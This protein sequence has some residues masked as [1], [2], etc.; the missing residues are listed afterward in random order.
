MRPFNLFPQSIGSVSNPV[1]KENDSNPQYS[2]PVPTD[3]ISVEDPVKSSVD[4]FKSSSVASF[5]SVP[6]ICP[7]K[8]PDNSIDN[9]VDCNFELVDTNSSILPEC[10]NSVPNCENN[11]GKDPKQALE[12]E[13]GLEPPIGS[14]TPIDYV[15]PP[16]EEDRSWIHAEGI[17]RIY[18]DCLLYTVPK[19]IPQP[20]IVGDVGTPKGVNLATPMN[21]AAGV[22]SGVVPNYPVSPNEMNVNYPMP[23]YPFTPTTISPPIPL[24]NP[25]PTLLVEDPATAKDLLKSNQIPSV[26]HMSSRSQ[27]NLQILVGSPTNYERTTTNGDMSVRSIGPP[28]GFEPEPQYPGTPFT[29]YPID[30]PLTGPPGH[31]YF[32]HST[33]TPMPISLGNPLDSRDREEIA[34]LN[35]LHSKHVITPVTP[36]NLFDIYVEHVGPNNLESNEEVLERRR[37]QYAAIL[38]LSQESTNL[39]ANVQPPAKEPVSPWG[40]HVPTHFTPS[41][42]M[43]KS[44]SQSNIFNEND[45]P[46][47]QFNSMES[48]R[49]RPLKIDTVTGGNPAYNPMSCPLPNRR[50][51]MSSL[52]FSSPTHERRT[53]KMPSAS[54]S[55]FGTFKGIA[56]VLTKVQ[57]QNII[58][59]SLACHPNAIASSVYCESAPLPRLLMS[60]DDLSMIENAHINVSLQKTSLGHLG[61]Q[62]LCTSTPRNYPAIRSQK[63]FEEQLVQQVVKMQGISGIPLSLLL[64]S[65]RLNNSSKLETVNE[66]VEHDSEDG[67]VEDQ[68][69]AQS[70]SQTV[71][72]ETLFDQSNQQSENTAPNSSLPDPSTVVD[73]SQAPLAHERTNP[74]L[75]SDLKYMSPNESITNLKGSMMLALLKA[76]ALKNHLMI[77]ADTPTR[78]LFI[79][80]AYIEELAFLVDTV[81]LLTKH[82]ENLELVQFL[83]IQVS[84]A[85]DM[86]SNLTEVRWKVRAALQ[87]AYWTQ[88]WPGTI[89]PHQIE[90]P[91][92]LLVK[93]HKG[94]KMLNRFL[95]LLDHLYSVSVS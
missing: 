78:L 4:P 67:A 13:G 36:V 94:R 75:G 52:Q 56:P 58:G 38:K 33:T 11:L 49:R 35:I 59:A 27:I 77:G 19:T 16:N 79:Y 74:I 43:H 20:G 48:S 61:R 90:N 24:A 64:K 65:H 45:Y 81:R 1:Y 6:A 83:S 7:P 63:K 72:P 32:A 66:G 26:A 87:Y 40:I 47:G 12:S 89:C 60:G 31:P 71:S 23:A 34:L 54:V 10:V 3:V 53:F 28:P 21:T 2:N 69:P 73:Q 68:S 95:P 41:F 29:P 18:T 85:L 25:F 57:Q 50:T 39:E 86:E 91:L 30:T 5:G 80:S 37:R 70:K 92:Y 62:P 15:A 55:T 82:V 88:Y 17:R 46:M 76:N 51:L 93:V 84:L 9:R 8:M 42:G 22:R 44:V 14:F